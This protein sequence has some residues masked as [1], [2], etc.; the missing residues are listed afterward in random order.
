MRKLKAIIF[1]FWKFSQEF[2]KNILLEDYRE[3]YREGMREDKKSNIIDV[4]A[5]YDFCTSVTQTEASF[6]SSLF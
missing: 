2:W 6:P 3:D 1:E 5:T 4:A